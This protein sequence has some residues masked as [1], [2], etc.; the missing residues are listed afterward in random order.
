VAG[1]SHLNLYYS[2]TASL[3]A[4]GLSTDRDSKHKAQEWSYEYGYKVLQR[5]FCHHTSHSIYIIV[6]IAAVLYRVFHDLL[7][8]LQEVIS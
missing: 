7:T 8:L 3:C 2:Y 4:R 6:F 1:V 5:M